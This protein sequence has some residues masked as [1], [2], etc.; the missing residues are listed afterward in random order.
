MHWVIFVEGVFKKQVA[1]EKVLLWFLK[2]ECKNSLDI[3]STSTVGF[4]KGLS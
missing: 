1:V 4:K 2:I 3:S